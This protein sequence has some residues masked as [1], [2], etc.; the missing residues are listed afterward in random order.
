[1]FGLKTKKEKEIAIKDFLHK[2]LSDKL[3]IIAD[4]ADDSLYMK[5]G[6]N[7]VL[8]KIKSMDN[9][10][11]RVVKS[12]LKYSR[13]K[14]NIDRLLGGMSEAMQL[15]IK[16]GNQF[17]QWIDGALFAISKKISLTKHEDAKE[18]S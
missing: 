5:Y 6:K 3:I 2:H 15:S 10:N 1:M 17:W 11:Y 9:K 12:V 8:T 18:K 16:D 13:F 4:P 14:S 7:F